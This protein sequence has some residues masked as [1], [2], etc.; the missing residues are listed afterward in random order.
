[1]NR[2][3]S[4]R[5]DKRTGRKVFCGYPRCH[6]QLGILMGGFP[7][8]DEEMVLLMPYFWADVHPSGEVTWRP[9]HHR[10]KSLDYGFAGIMRRPR[11]VQ[12]VTVVPRNHVATEQSVRLLPHPPDPYL[13]YHPVLPPAVVVCPVCNTSNGL[14]AEL[15]LH[16]GGG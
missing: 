12:E 2:V 13:R 10:F 3:V 7:N 1:M 4:A 5:L 9:S 8:A 6:G 11:A 16:H 15:L 14:V